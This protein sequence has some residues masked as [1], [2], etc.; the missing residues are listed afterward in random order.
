MITKPKNYEEVQAFDGEFESLDVGGHIL[1][2][3]GTK[4]E[5]Y[6]WGQVLILAIDIAEGEHKGYYQ[7]RYDRDK[8]ASS[9][10]KWKGTYRQPIPSDNDKDSRTSSFFK[11]L[12]TAIE[13]SN[14]GYTF[15]WDE[16]TLVN[17]F[18]GGVF[19]RREFIRDDGESIWYTEMRAP[20]DVAKIRSGD[21]KIPEDKP[22][23]DQ[24]AK[25]ED[26]NDDTSLPF[27]L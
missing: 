21:F 20:R 2:I 17:K 14:P 24:S 6:D 13:R 5:E 7:R 26:S 9:D 18:V 15:N 25:I 19:G 23:K 22:A 27:D 16:K 3:V 1:K 10:A 11:G 8:A 12:I 4:V